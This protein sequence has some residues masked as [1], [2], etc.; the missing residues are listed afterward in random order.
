MANESFPEMPTIN[1]IYIFDVYILTIVLPFAA[2]CIE[3]VGSK[4]Q[5]SVAVVAKWFLFFAVGIRFMLGGIR[6]A[7]GAKRKTGE[8]FYIEK[9]Q[10]CPIV[11]ELGFANLSLGVVAAISLVIPSWRVVSAFSSCLYYGAAA[12]SYFFM[13][14]ASANETFIMISNSCISLILLILLLEIA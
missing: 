5:L 2:M 12:V 13:K 3:A 11:K 4:G 6:Q 8:I 14:R 10:C 7:I 1:K 9:K